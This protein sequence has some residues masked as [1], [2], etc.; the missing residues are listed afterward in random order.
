NI[1]EL[2]NLVERMVVLAHGQVLD[3][4]DIPPQVREKAYGGGE[5]RID[6]ELTVDEM[7]RRMIIQALEKTNGNRTKAAEKLGISRRTLH[8][9]LNQY[10]IH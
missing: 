10:E 9:K 2:R 7:E 5:V 4:A 1:R 6:A 8:R 3:I